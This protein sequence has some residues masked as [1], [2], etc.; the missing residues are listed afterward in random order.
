M[1][2][3]KVFVYKNRTYLLHLLLW[4]KVAVTYRRPAHINNTQRIQTWASDAFRVISSPSGTKFAHRKLE[5][6]LSCGKNPASLSHLGLNR[7]RVVTDGRTE[8]R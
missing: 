5:T 7:Y 4:S 3:I 2:L 6:T 8:L 1:M